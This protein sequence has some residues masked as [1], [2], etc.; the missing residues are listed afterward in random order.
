MKKI[1]FASLACAALASGSA[2][3]ADMRVKAPILKAPP[4]VVYNWTGCYIGGNV[5]GG[6]ARTEQLQVAKVT[7]PIPVVP[8]NNFGS[9]DGSAFI[10]GGQFGCDYQVGGNFVIGVQGKADF[11]TISSSH[12]VATAFPGLPVGSFNSSDDT[13]NMYTATGRI[14]YLVTPPV[15]LYVKGGGA[16]TRTESNIFGNIPFVFLSES[17]SADRSGWTVGGGIEWMFAPGWSIF[18]EY[19]YMDF[20]N[21]DISYTR[22]PLASLNSEDVIRTRLTASQALFGVNWRF[23]MMMG[24]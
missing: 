18:G 9:G 5:G 23:N 12:A 8:P 21:L 11:G 14:G 22:G 7:P 20:G 3:A 2:I 15:L 24:H 6:W 16:W 10:G 1:L 17:A 4:P 19:N 13:K